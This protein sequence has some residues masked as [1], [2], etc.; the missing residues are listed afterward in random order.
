MWAN[1]H[2]PRTAFIPIS[3]LS[4]LQVRVFTYLIGREMTFAE[5]VKWIACNNKGKNQIRINCE[6]E[7]Q[8]NKNLFLCIWN[9]L[10]SSKK[11]TGGA[12]TLYGFPRWWCMELGIRW[13]PLVNYTGSC[14]GS[15]LKI[16]ALYSSEHIQNPSLNTWLSE[17]IHCKHVHIQKM[18]LYVC[19]GVCVCVLGNRCTPFCRVRWQLLELTV[20]YVS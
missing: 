11:N 20:K 5:N 6:H 7:G 13:C 8:K 2:V 16:I 19:L 15:D 12:L 9:L 3:V 18:H 17:R 14:S 1:K 10:W 4:P